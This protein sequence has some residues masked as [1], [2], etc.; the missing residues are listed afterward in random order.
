MATARSW[1]NLFQIYSGDSAL[2]RETP[3]PAPILS[4]LFWR[5]TPKAVLDLYA[6]IGFQIYSGDSLSDQFHPA[7]LSKLPFKSILEIPVF[8]EI[9]EEHKYTRSFQIYSGDSIALPPHDQE[10]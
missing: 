1:S 10:C 9:L 8:R 6:G 5:F 3:H 2:I 4:N 7:L